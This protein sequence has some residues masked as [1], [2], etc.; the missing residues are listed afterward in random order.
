MVIHRSG[1]HIAMYID[2][3]EVA[4]NGWGELDEKQLRVLADEALGELGLSAV[5]PRE[6]ESYAAADGGALVFVRLAGDG[7]NPAHVE[8]FY[9]FSDEA[10]LRE[11]KDFW[12][13]ELADPKV[14]F[15]DG[16]YILAL[17]GSGRDFEVMLFR[18]C[19]FGVRLRAGALFRAVLEEHGRKC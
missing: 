17:S 13:A 15:Y 11:A 5:P 18:L 9:A 10:D 8:A 1:R 3:A 14:F 6:I 7:E 4:A 2:G 19:E 12:E 16:Q